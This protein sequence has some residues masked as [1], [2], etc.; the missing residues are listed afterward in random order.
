M[1]R[2]AGGSQDLPL[3]LNAHQSQIRRRTY[4]TITK[5]ED[6]H[7]KKRKVPHY[8]DIH[9]SIHECKEYVQQAYKWMVID[10]TCGLCVGRWCRHDGYFYLLL[11]LSPEVNITPISFLW[12]DT[13]TSF[14]VRA[15]NTLIGWV[16]YEEGNQYRCTI[17]LN[18]EVI[19]T[20]QHSI[21]MG[22]T[23]SIL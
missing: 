21:S 16:C 20:A 6:A 17:Q 3:D 1:A 2:L 13:E 22:I 19:G 18:N 5:W 10:I 11:F 4:E 12:A 8:C 15:S 9:V 7:N 23:Y 14:L